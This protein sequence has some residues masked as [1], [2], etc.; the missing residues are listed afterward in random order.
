MDKPPNYGEQN[1]SSLIAEL[2][3]DHPGEATREE[4]AEQVDKD[5]GAIAE[6]LQSAYVA[7]QSGSNSQ[8]PKRGIMMVVTICD[9]GGHIR[10][11]QTIETTIEADKLDSKV[12][13]LH[14]CVS[15]SLHAISEK[16][17]ILSAAETI[18]VI[19]RVKY[20]CHTIE[21]LRFGSDGKHSWRVPASSGDFYLGY[22]MWREPEFEHA[23]GEAAL[24]QAQMLLD[25]LF[26]LEEIRISEVES[27]RGVK[28]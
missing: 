11:E 23:T 18:E 3:L 7:G 13:H 26:E 15:D 19:E 28:L 25:K 16:L 4:D 27:A 1:A 2:G 12:Q 10:V 17:E 9:D 8:L 24:R 14:R 22:G 20:R 5:F 6:A 21:V